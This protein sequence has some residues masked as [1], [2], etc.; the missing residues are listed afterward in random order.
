HNRIRLVLFDHGLSVEHLAESVASIGGKLDHTI[1]VSSVPKEKL[2]SLEAEIFNLFN[3]NR[4]HTTVYPN[5]V[6]GENT[7]FIVNIFF[8]IL[9]YPDDNISQRMPPQKDIYP[10]GVQYPPHGSGS[11]SLLIDDAGMNLALADRLTKLN[12]PFTVAII[13]HTTYA[14][15]T[16]ELVRSRGKGV[17]LHFPMQPD[18]YPS[19]DPGEGAVFVDMPQ[20]VI[21]AVTDSNAA[22]IG[23]ID[24]ANNHMGST[25][26]ADEEKI[27][28]VLIA[29][30]KY[31]DTF[32]DSKTSPNTA[33]YRVCREL[34][35]KCAQNQRF[36]DNENDHV[37]ITKKLYEAFTAADKTEPMVVIGHLRLNTVDVLET[38]VPEL[39]ARGYRFIPMSAIVQ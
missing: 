38:V 8:I 34:G 36:L 3:L 30:S 25:M 29:L 14:R 33:A 1:T 7:E 12:I 39:L 23:K 32:V 28:Q 27:R 24:G 9:E 17:F 22:N 6:R 16:A 37:Y 20:A 4:L 5:R 35:L 2:R 31:T 11:I 15:Q 10:F 19:V 26:T 18:G 13:P 21:E